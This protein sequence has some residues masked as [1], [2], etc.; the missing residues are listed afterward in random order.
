MPLG[1]GTLCGTPI[2]LFNQQE[3][4]YAFIPHIIE[5]ERSFW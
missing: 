3:C 1:L 4:F 5:Y 2:A